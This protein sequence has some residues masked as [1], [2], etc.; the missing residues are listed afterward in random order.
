MWVKKKLNNHTFKFERNN[1][2]IFQKISVDLNI[3][4]H[5]SCAERHQLVPFSNNQSGAV[6]QSFVRLHLL[7]ATDTGP[8][9]GGHTVIT[10][11][12]VKP[13]T[14]RS[15]LLFNHYPTPKL[16]HDE[17]KKSKLLLNQMCKLG[18]PDI[19]RDFIEV[20]TKFLQSSRHLSLNALQQMLNRAA[21]ICSANG[22]WVSYN[23]TVLFFTEKK[24]IANF[25]KSCAGQFTVHWQYGGCA[26]NARSNSQQCGARCCC[27]IMANIVNK[28]S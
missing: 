5:I 1:F 19:Q 24:K 9:A 2:N 27:A 28:S 6:T 3:Y 15:S 25:Q 11:V 13:I 16:T 18:Y 8:V 23:N 21:S 26:N 10:M 4:D 14:R 17:N 20:F 22:K 12:E 7:D